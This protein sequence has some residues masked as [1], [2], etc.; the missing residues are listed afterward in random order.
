M[1]SIVSSADLCAGDVSLSGSDYRWHV[2][3]VNSLLPLATHAEVRQRAAAQSAVLSLGAGGSWPG[4]ALLSA[5]CE[6]LPC[7]FSSQ[8]L[9]DL[10]KMPTCVGPVRRLILDQLGNRYHRRFAS[11]WAFVLYARE[12]GLNLDF[13]T[14]P[15]RPPRTL[16]P[17]PGR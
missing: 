4:L 13:T 8:E 6:P 5:A 17:W 15:K 14:P 10:L 12:H 11:Q 16:P 3:A 7:R 1:R 9:V 2:D